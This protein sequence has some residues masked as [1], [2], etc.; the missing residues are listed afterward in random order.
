MG[1]QVGRGGV[2]CAIAGVRCMLCGIYGWCVWYVWGRWG[3]LWPSEVSSFMT[4]RPL[5]PALS[6]GEDAGG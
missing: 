3:T 4:V 5:A 6:D 1:R 2:Q